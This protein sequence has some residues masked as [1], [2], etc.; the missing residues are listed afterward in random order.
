MIA[1]AWATALMVMD[2]EIGYEKV[3]NNPEIDAVW[4][5][6]DSE[7]GNRYVSKSGN[8]EIKELKYLIK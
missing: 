6:K 8:M 3:N 5:M 4:I 1:D 2:Y 7:D